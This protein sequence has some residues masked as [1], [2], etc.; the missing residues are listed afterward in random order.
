MST[1]YKSLAENCLVVIDAGD[2]DVHFEI[3]LEE[4]RSA[5]SVLL[6]AVQVHDL[7]NDLVSIMERHDR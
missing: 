1:A 6:L 7:I 2:G 5:D 4:G 3:V